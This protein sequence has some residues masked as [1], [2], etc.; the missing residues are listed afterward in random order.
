[1]KKIIN[2]CQSYYLSDEGQTLVEYAMIILFVVVLAV[3]AVTL[4]G[5]S[6]V[7]VLWQQAAGAL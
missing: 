7:N 5:N 4:L 2:F 6:V 1:M 3:V